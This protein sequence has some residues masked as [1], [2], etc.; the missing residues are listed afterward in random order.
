MGSI[1]QKIAEIENTDGKAAL[2]M[3]VNTK[4]STPRKPGAKMIV[5]ADGQIYGTIGGGTLEKAVIENALRVVEKKKSK[6]FKH[7]LV[8]DHGMCCGGTVEIFIEPIMTK[9]KLYIFGAGHIGKALAKFAKELDFNVSIIDERDDAFDNSG[10]VNFTCIH[11]NHKRAF[12]DLVFDENTFV[13]VITHNH[14]YD[15]EIVAHCAK[16]PHAYLG[17]I[18]SQRKIEIAKKTFRTGNI[19]TLKEMK[20]INWPMGVPIDVQTPEEIAIAILAKLIDTRS[21]QNKQP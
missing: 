9:K 13:T 21:K 12:K 15:R 16:Q 7:A 4:G 20:N 14:A 2:C 1:Y 19:L 17:M 11:K 10:L 18:G 6:I 8:H 5:Y 3:V